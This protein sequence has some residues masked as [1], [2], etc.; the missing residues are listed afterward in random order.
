MI[1]EQLK[2]N[3]KNEMEAELKCRLIPF[4]KGLYDDKNGGFYGSVDF[5][6]NVDKNAN[7]GAILNSRILWFFSSCHM[8]YKD[9]NCLRFADYAFDFLINRFLDR[10]YGGLFWKVDCEGNVVDATKHTYNLSFAIYALSRYYKASENRSALELA[11]DLY[12]FVEKKAF[13]GNGYLEQ[14]DVKWNPQENKQLSEHGVMAERTMNT[15]LHLIEAYTELYKISGSEDVKR[16]IEILLDIFGCKIYN[17]KKRRLDVFFDEDWNS[18]LDMHSYGHDIE[19]SWL[20]DHAA[21]AINAEPISYTAS[22]SEEILKKGYSEK[23]VFNEALSG[24]IDRSKIWWVQAESVV[25]FFNMYEKSGDESYLDAVLSLWNF[26]KNNFFDERSGEWFSEL[27]SS[28]VPRNMEVV[29]PWKCPYHNGR[30][31]IEIIGRLS[32]NV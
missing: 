27:D 30:M 1:S 13:C 23:G 3:L 25:G 29:S 12:A 15:S 5:Y 14:F 4:W 9:E 31:C 32:R 24:V 20:L 8:L 21:Q 2:K 16:S 28:G 17:Q 11:L 19:A 6:G 26:I 7:K 10:K 22:L 18:L